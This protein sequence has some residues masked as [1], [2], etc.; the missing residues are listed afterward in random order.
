MAFTSGAFDYL[1][2][3]E[4]SSFNAICSLNYYLRGNL[5]LERLIVNFLML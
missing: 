5:V 4:L 3:I 2:N 1:T